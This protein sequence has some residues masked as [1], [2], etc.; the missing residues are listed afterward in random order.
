[1]TQLAGLQVSKDS[2]KT[3]EIF[4]KVQYKGKMVIAGRGVGAAKPAERVHARNAKSQERQCR[5][6]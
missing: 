4:K 2:E 1:L 5:K 3:G 6:G